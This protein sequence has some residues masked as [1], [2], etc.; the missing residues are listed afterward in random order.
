[1][2][3]KE[4]ALG[5]LFL[6]LF[7]GVY[8]ADVVITE[9]ESLCIDVVLDLVEK[10][11]YHVCNTFL[12]MRSLLAGITACKLHS[13]V[14]KISS[15]HCKTYRNTL[16]LPLCKLESRTESVTAVDLDSDAL[17]LKLLLECRHLVEDC[18]VHSLI[19]SCDRNH[20]YLDRS[21]LRRKHETVVV[22]VSHDEGTHKTCR[23][24]P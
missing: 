2:A 7:P 19:L 16:E 21:E 4:S 14:L 8:L 10:R 1:M 11:C 12:R 18:I 17:S 15:A 24:A 3:E 6:E 23:N 13:A 20:H 22:S 9:L 5:D